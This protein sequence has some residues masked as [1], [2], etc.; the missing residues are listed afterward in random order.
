LSKRRHEPPRI[1]GDLLSGGIA[2]K[3]ARS[4]Q[5]QLTIAK[6]PL[7]NGFDNLAPIGGRFSKN[8]TFSGRREVRWGGGWGHGRSGSDAGLGATA[9]GA[10][11]AAAPEALD[12]DHVAAANRGHGGRWSAAARAAR[13]RRHAPSRDRS[14]AVVRRSALLARAMFTLRVAVA[15]NP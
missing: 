1:V 9:G 15:S 11:S 13:R 3:Q 2:E 4:D 6:L 10:G 8:R 12:D 5:Y 14:T 7:A